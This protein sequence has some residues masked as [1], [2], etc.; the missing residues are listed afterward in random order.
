VSQLETAPTEHTAPPPFTPDRGDP[1]A[2]AA[3]ATHLLYRQHSQRILAFCI[4]RLRNRQDAEDALQ[5]TFAY[6]FNALRRGV[7]PESELAWLFTIAHN[8]C[9]TRQRSLRRRSQL[10]TSTDPTTLEERAP[11]GRSKGDELSGLREALLS[12]PA[13]QRR[14]LLLREWQGLSYREIAGEL[15]VSESAVETL[16]FRAR[17]TLAERLQPTA[18]QAVL[19][20]TPTP[21]I[22]LVRRLASAGAGAKTAAATLALSLATA[23]PYATH[24][25]HPPRAPAGRADKSVAD[26]PSNDRPARATDSRLARAPAPTISAAASRA[27]DASRTQRAR[28]EPAAAAPWQSAPP[29]AAPQPLEAPRP[30][31]LPPTGQAG[32]PLAADEAPLTLPPLPQPPLLQATIPPLP[33]LPPLPPRPPAATPPLPAAPALPPTTV[34][35]PPSTPAPP[36]G[37]EQ[38]VLPVTTA[39]LSSPRSLPGPVADVTRVG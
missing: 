8:A 34:T 18:G 15:A 27:I 9:R 21:L 22:R 19:L 12:I 25:A 26:Q 24:L 6:A 1:N 28:S 11:A 16:L 32:L 20:L 30:P 35:T 2:L 36:T 14:A 38:P 5:T 39:E 37:T 7:E 10:E 23:A 17:R 4:S 3:E 13:S 29:S 31:A 33:P